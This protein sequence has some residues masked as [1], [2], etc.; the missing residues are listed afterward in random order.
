[1]STWRRAAAL[2]RRRLRLHTATDR[3]DARERFGRGYSRWIQFEAAK[4]A[5]G[6]TLLLRTNDVEAVCEAITSNGIGRVVGPLELDG[7]TEALLIDLEGN[8]VMITD[9]V[10]CDIDSDSALR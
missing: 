4:T 7:H 10:A 1:V 9:L 8:R 6:V 5:A 2:Y 3:R